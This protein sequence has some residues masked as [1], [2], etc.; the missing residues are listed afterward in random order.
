M[1][2][3]FGFGYH[4]L[5]CQHFSCVSSYGLSV[6]VYIVAG[7]KYL[8][9]ILTLLSLVDLLIEMS[10]SSVVDTKFLPIF[11]LCFCPFPL[12]KVRLSRICLHSCAVIMT[13]LLSSL[14]MSFVV[15]KFDGLLI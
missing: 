12:V 14:L 11:S 3:Y 13:G 6:A 1:L 4:Y 10:P 2:I 15:L 7:W 9:N 8:I 5:L